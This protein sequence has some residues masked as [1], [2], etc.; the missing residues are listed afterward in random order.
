MMVGGVSSAE[1]TSMK[2]STMPSMVT[3]CT[4]V[5]SALSASTSTS[6]PGYPTICGT[7]GELSDLRSSSGQHPVEPVEGAGV[8]ERAGA[9]LAVVARTLGG[10]EGAEL[11]RAAQRRGQLRGRSADV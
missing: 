3:F 7:V 8:E 1:T 2:R 10:G 9:R 6:K 5:G 4:G 11:V